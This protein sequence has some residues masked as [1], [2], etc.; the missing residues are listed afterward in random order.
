MERSFS[1]CQTVCASADPALNN[2]SFL[3]LW[4]RFSLDGC[5]LTLTPGEPCT[6]C[7][8]AAVIP[9]LPEGKEYVLSVTEQGI[10]VRGS[11]YGGL[12]RGLMVLMMKTE[13]SDGQCVI[14][15]CSETDAYTLRNRMI[16]FCYFPETDFYFMKKAIRLAALCQYTHVVLEF[17][18]MLQYDCLKELAWPHALSKSQAAELIR[19]CRELGMEPIPMYNQ[20]GHATGSRL[21]YGKHVVLDQNPRLQ[22]LFTPDGW[23]WNIQSAQTAALLKSIRAE[24]YELFGPGEYM[25]I[26]CD[27]AYY[28][29]RDAS[30]RKD[31][32]RYLADLTAEVEAE[33]RRPMLWMDMLLEEK[34]FPGCYTVGKADE[35]EKLRRDTAPSTV[36]VD[37]QYDCITTPIPSLVSLKDCGRDVIGAPWYDVKNYRAHIDTVREHDFSGI[38]LTTWHTLKTYMPSI[39]GCAQAFGAR[40]FSWSAFSGLHEETATLLRRV[41][42]EGNTYADCGWSREQVET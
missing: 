8:G 14:P 36:F 29:T 42:I 33:G 24:L 19:E 12:L 27:E 18:G 22:P 25:H 4:K 31:L 26:G 2:P 6:F 13:T 23:A 39:L 3:N 1:L 15:V 5:S 21:C 37:W 28:I 34:K 16:H 17:W 7:V 9:E 20:L 35:V 40:T 32:P 30:L 11:S 41:S 10:A 38:M